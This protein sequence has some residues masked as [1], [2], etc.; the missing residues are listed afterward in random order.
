MMSGR[1]YV[2][3]RNAALGILVLTALSFL[4]HA[5]PGLLGSLQNSPS[6]QGSGSAITGRASS[7]VYIVERFVSV[8]CSSLLYGSWNLVSS[9]CTISNKSAESAFSS[10]GVSLISAHR[11]Q[12]LDT[13]DP[14]KAYSPWIDGFAVQDIGNFSDMSGYWVDLNASATLFSVGNIT[15]PNFIPLK[16]GWNLIG[17]TSN[18]TKNIT[19]ALSSISGNYDSVHA[20]FANETLDHW[21]VYEP[22][23]DPA[24]SDLHY[25]QPYHGYWI[26]MTANATLEVI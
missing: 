12:V 14:W 24:L 11:Y 7:T 19:L 2:I 8:N 6:G 9:P 18:E 23:L 25:M 13:K 4:L 22:N 1:S 16:T 3:V 5:V 26:H 21:K 20:Y 10:L 15:L 17:W